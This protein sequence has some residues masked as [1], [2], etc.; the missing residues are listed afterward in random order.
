MGPQRVKNFGSLVPVHSSRQI[1]RFSDMYLKMY[2][3]WLDNFQTLSGQDQPLVPSSVIQLIS[4]TKIWGTEPSFWSSWLAF[5]FKNSIVINY[6]EYH[7]P[8]LKIGCKQ[9][10]LNHM[11]RCD[12]N[13]E[14][15][16]TSLFSVCRN[17]RTR[18]L[19]VHIIYIDH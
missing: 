19:F 3:K 13:I 11:I 6:S 18:N 14:S 17:F 12:N 8:W 2:K 15:Y 7:F 4:A 5:Y 9:T 1:G 10:Q 16:L